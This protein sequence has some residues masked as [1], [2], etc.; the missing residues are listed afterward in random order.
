MPAHKL[1]HISHSHSFTLCQTLA[2]CGAYLCY[3]LCAPITYIHSARF[4]ICTCVDGAQNV[5]ATIPETTTTPTTTSTRLLANC[6]NGWLTDGL[7]LS[8]SAST[9]AVVCRSRTRTFICKKA[10]HS[11]ISTQTHIHTHV[12][13]HRHRETNDRTVWRKRW[14]NSDSWFAYFV[15]AC[16]FVVKP[17]N[18][19]RPTAHTW[20]KCTTMDDNTTPAN[21]FERECNSKT[22]KIGQLF[23]SKL[24]QHECNSIGAKNYRNKIFD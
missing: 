16:W 20:C 13:H 14:Q 2:R 23:R 24:I 10:Y 1:T 22:L 12:L 9:S 7:D 6:T 3:K 17:H 19:C 18:E 21:A 4:S 11:S 8:S 5:A 15:R